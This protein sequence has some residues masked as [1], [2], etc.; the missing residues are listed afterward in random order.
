[1]KKNFFLLVL[2]LLLS[3][4]DLVLRAQSVPVINWQTVDSLVKKQ[5]YSQAYNLSE[6][7]FKKALKSGDSRNM[8]VGSC[9]MSIVGDYYR[10]DDMDSTLVRLE[11]ILP[12]LNDVDAAVCRLF[13]AEYYTNYYSQNL[14]SIHLNA[15]MDEETDDY[16]L[17]DGNR[18]KKQIT[19]LVY[20]AFRSSSLMKSTSSES[21]GSL[22]K[23]YKGKDGDLTPTFFDVAMHSFLD[24]LTEMKMTF[25]GIDNAAL[26]YYA[27]EQFTKAQFDVKSSSDLAPLA[28]FTIKKMQEWEQL[29]LERG[30]KDGLMIKMYHDRLDRVNQLFPLKKEVVSRLMEAGLK[31]VIERYRNCGDG[32]AALLYNQLSKLYLN[33]ERRVEAV[34]VIDTAV[35]LFPGTP[36]AVSC[37]N[38]RLII[39]KKSV[40]V[41]Q[42]SVVPSSRSHIASI[43]TKNT[44]RLYFRIVKS[45]EC[46]KKYDNSEKKCLLA[47]NVLKQWSLNL[48]K[49][50][51]YKPHTTIVSIP[52][53]PQGDYCLLV[54]ADNSNF[55]SG[56]VASYFTV[57]DLVFVAA[58]NHD[59]KSGFLIDR[60]SGKPV[61][62]ASVTLEYK[63]GYGSKWSKHATMVTDKDGFFDFSSFPLNKDKYT[64]YTSFRVYTTY[65]GRR[66]VSDAPYY[67]SDYYDT[68]NNKKDDI[69]Y[70]VF[71]DRPIY[72][73]GDTVGFF[74]L[75]YSLA[76][77]DAKVIAGERLRV[78]LKDINSKT[79]DTI[80]LKTDSL[81]ETSGHFLVP[82][83]ATP[84]SWKIVF[85]GNKY[86]TSSFTVE[87]YKQP[88]FSVVLNMTEQR[89]HFGDTTVVEGMATSYS[90]VPVAGAEVS[91][92]IVRN[93]MQQFWR[94]GWWPARTT[95]STVVAEGV[96]A[97]DNQG[98]FRIEYVPTPDSNSTTENPVF[99]Y[100]V[101]AK[102]TDI[103]GETHE[104]TTSFAVGS[105]NSYINYD[106]E[107]KNCDSVNIAITHK[108]LDGKDISGNLKIK[109]FRLCQP[110]S[111]KLENSVMTYAMSEDSNASMSLTRSQFD[112]QFPLFD[113]D[114]TVSNYELWPVDKMIFEDNASVGR[115]KPYN[116]SMAG[117][118]KGMYRFEVRML[119]GN[120]TISTVFYNSYE[121]RASKQ[122]LLSK[123]IVAELES[124]QVEVGDS[125]RVRV[126]SRF[127][128][129]TLY[130]VMNKNGQKCKHR[131]C[132]I[133][134]EY[135]KLTFPVSESMLGGVK[136]ELM[137]V[138]ENE[139]EIQSY[140]VVVPYSHKNLE[141]E[142]VTFRDKLEP[143]H[144]EQWTFRIKQKKTGDPISAA[145]ALTMYDH[146]I[147]SYYGDVA[148]MKFAPWKMSF[149]GPAFSNVNTMTYGSVDFLPSLNYKTSDSYSYTYRILNGI[150]R[151]SYLF[152]FA[153]SYVGGVKNGIGRNKT[154]RKYALQEESSAL[155]EVTTE[156]EI[157]DD[158][159]IMAE[160]VAVIENELGI[161]DAVDENS[162]KNSNVYV[163]EN[164][165]TL[166][167][168][169]PMLRSEADGTVEVSFSVPDLL[170]E[171]SIHGL[172]WTSDMKVGAMRTKAVTQKRLMA[173]PN[174]PRFLRHGD[175]CMF[176][177][178]VSNLSGNNQNVA[179]SLEMTDATT[180]N[181]LRMI[182]G[183]DTKYITIDDGA[184]GEVSF[185]L[186][187]PREALFVTKYKVVARGN[188]CSDG[189][190]ATIPL[191][192]SRQLVTESMAFYINGQGEKTMELK[193]LTAIDTSAA[194]FT[195][196]NHSL[197]VDVTPN[198]LWLAL[199]S[200]PF[201]SR[202]QNPTN[203]YLA[204]S[205][206]ANSLSLAIVD[207][208]PQLKQMFDEWSAGDGD[209][210]ISELDRNS[211]IKQTIIEET[212]WLRD[213][214]KEEQRHR[215]ISIFFDKAR[216]NRQLEQDINRLLDAQRAD[217]GWSW[218][219]GARYSSLYTTQYILKTFGV[220]RQQ[221]VTLSSRVNYAL[222]RAM[223]YV[224][225][226]TYNY[227]KKYIKNQG[228]EVVNLDYLYIRSY[229]TSN[230]MSKQQ[231]EAYDYFYNNAKKKNADFK[232]LYSQAMMSVVFNRNG[233]TKLAKEM[234]MRIKEKALYSDEMGMYWRDNN[235][236]WL[237]YQRPIET[238]AMLIRTFHEVLDE[239]E[240][241]A[242]MQQ[243]L[244]KQKQTTNWSTD[245]STV[246]AI[247]ALL[248]ARPDQGALFTPSRMSV[249]YGS[250]RLS[251]DSPLH[252]LHVSQR[253]S[254]SDITPDDGKVTIRKEDDGIAW[255]AVYWQYF[256]NV[257]KIPYSSTG[258]TLKGSL[259]KV[260][261]DGSLSVVKDGG[262]TS[263]QVGDKVRVRI[264]ISADRNMEY[265]ELKIPRCAAMEP[266][267]SASGWHWNG[268]LSYYYSVTNASE[269][270]YID[271]LDKG[272]YL[273]EYDLYVNNAGT[274]VTAPIT[275]QCLYAPEFR[276][277]LPSMKLKIKE[278]R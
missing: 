108:N 1:M 138:R 42:G 29:H 244:L 110:S 217:G 105:H 228:Y 236:G 92:S 196:S 81:G 152:H 50:Y 128:D 23:I 253:L 218:I 120:D 243:W 62:S 93:E 208:N 121:P 37:E 266:V 2:A 57:E 203:I 74:I 13:M 198:P 184:S 15:A 277:T 28:M 153:D 45:S 47:Q 166:S 98:L 146:A 71:F 34:N 32:R 147:D 130:V 197:T 65:K 12:R 77:M 164:L 79:I 181:N 190:Q 167:F 161:V 38:R 20:E 36:G 201:V 278:K 58:T 48:E 24:I 169:Q 26:L 143:G 44:D 116:Y 148:W 89:R 88:K 61:A 21:L 195:L 100:E 211:D 216:I 106:I 269:T 254:A 274:F 258:I 67:Y 9:Y 102:V 140:N 178:K 3:V 223:D 188:D 242:K 103:N 264:E 172:A 112:E 273:L 241:V 19:E 80:S 275:M 252:Q 206:Y 175:T 127:K 205:I 115:D 160:E 180:G 271:R 114:G 75:A 83:D 149:S 125:I 139:S 66:I 8:L 137:A 239:D 84:G 126:G 263:L 176:S 255:G 96:T 262:A 101:R 261:Q 49:Y 132:H 145:L 111:P 86:N 123:L 131:I 69:N 189:E 158:D 162:T 174:V 56:F 95:E 221:G 109:V 200:L 156:L 30:E 171:W 124:T 70:S 257:E 209:A 91:Y 270:L 207:A 43:V 215:D 117:L 165:N 82:V 33:E 113:Y 168:F 118:P 97:T 141:I 22:T 202:Q 240:N 46:Q 248:I 249:S 27:P 63:K 60:V 237:W 16:T 99:S 186:A 230:N 73:P 64:P 4:S 59:I 72:K 31:Q 6:K 210:F 39:T 17:W 251:T 35:A 18:F 177:V 185:Q 267:S 52:S 40:D 259:Y 122:P 150:N 144:V 192:P 154:L 155:P 87:S 187:V 55:D 170:T 191:L 76:D 256:E 219:A 90:A 179:V 183:D 194:N 7:Y 107:K 182:V 231:K 233:D 276:S 250:H 135:K 129:V 136:L 229:Y 268:G 41:K 235:N 193:H 85:K 213:A 204:N 68:Y 11:T 53:M 159:L 234:A 272:K 173:V 224:D 10:E 247:Q 238:Q 245:V 119:D 227:Y 265:L 78:E 142:T 222:N 225:R 104:T 226:E 14:F 134:N 163:R 5:Y 157:V 151:E 214:L 133:N 54:S 25:V 212:P 232:S 260:Q 220:L 94:W 51:D 199:Q 246:N